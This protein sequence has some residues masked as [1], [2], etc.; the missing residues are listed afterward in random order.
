MTS[1]KNDGNNVKREILRGSMV[2]ACID[3]FGIWT[4][5][6][7]DLVITLMRRMVIFLGEAKMVLL[8]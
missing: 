5:Q 8:T 3:R 1:E 4:D 7:N 6:E 2:Y